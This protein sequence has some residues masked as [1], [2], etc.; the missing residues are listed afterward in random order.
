MNLL[1]LLLGL[2][3]PRDSSNFTFK[4]YKRVLVASQRDVTNDFV[5][6]IAPMETLKNWD[7][8]LNRPVTMF[9]FKWH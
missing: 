3:S 6:R 5:G 1:K 9:K 4:V 8:D 7:L 2:T